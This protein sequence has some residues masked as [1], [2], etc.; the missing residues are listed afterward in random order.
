MDYGSFIS[1]EE[2]RK[3]DEGLQSLRSEKP[4]TVAPKKTESKK[5]ALEHSKVNVNQKTKINTQQAVKTSKT[6][7]VKTNKSQNLSKSKHEKKSLEKNSQKPFVVKTSIGAKLIGIISAIVTISLIL[8]TVLVSYYIS[9]DTRVN[10]EENNLTINS[11][12]AADTQSRFNS[13]IA[14][15]GTF[16]DNISS[17]DEAEELQNKAARFFERNS[18]LIAMKFIYDDKTFLNNK[19]FVSRELDSQMVHAYADQ[20]SESVDSAKNGMVSVLNACPF[21]ENQILAI[22]TPIRSD[23]NED[24]V[25]IL[26]SLEALSE[27]YSTGSANLSFL[28]NDDGNLI[29][30]PDLELM[31]S[32]A[33]IKDHYLVKNL[34]FS[35]SKAEQVTYKN[36]DGIEYIGAYTKLDIGSCAVITEIQTKVVLEAVYATTRRNI[37]LTI[38]ILSIA[39]MI[40]WFF[41]KSLSTPLKDLTAVTNEINAGNFETPLLSQMKVKRKDEIGVLVQSTKAEQEILNTFTRLT[42][43]GVTRAIVTKKIDFQPHL[44]DITIFFSDIRGFTAISDGFNKRFGEKSA[45]EII[46][47]LNDY[48]GRMVNC[49]SISGGNVD[50]FEGDAIMACWGVLR[51]DSLDYEKWPDSDPRKAKFK[52][53][54][55]KHVKQD[56]V[57]AIMATTAMR[58]ALMEYNK[59]AEAFTKAHEGEPKAKYKPHIRIGSGLNSGRA[60]VGFMGSYDKM[61]FTSIGD[62]VNLASRTE[63]SNKPCGTDMLITQDTYDLLKK[64]FIRCPE[65][66]YTIKPQNLKYEVVVEVIPV[67]FEVKGKGKQH[68]YGVVNMPQFDIEGFFRKGDP[69]FKLDP[70][71]AKAIG[72]KGPKTLAEVRSLLGIPTPDFGEVNLDAEESKIKAT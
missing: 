41:S 65:N 69:H 35:K 66:N 57:S 11:R 36:E 24:V 52:A 13:V 49:I 17:D 31:N 67:T 63:S 53:I 58:Y 34:P 33:E 30:H 71:C 18:D 8:I 29:I 32:G 1:R 50:K 26:S 22:F 6:L 42:N 56:A 46:G 37:Y 61:E 3:K 5:T 19:Y 51:D 59:K 9:S 44:K 43:K 38:A 7:S 47:F 39:I 64:D 68:F 15:A 72:P 4:V 21:F 54:H 23:D 48:M 25:M 62:A 70:D 45:G 28:V 12:T 16:Y 55:E 40:V 60:T 20:E 14:S 10:A 27:S 2:L